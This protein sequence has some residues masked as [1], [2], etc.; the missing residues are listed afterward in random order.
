M[1]VNSLDCPTMQSMVT[2]LLEKEKTALLS[3]EPIAGMSDGVTEAILEGVCLDHE[4]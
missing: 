2:D 1:Y 3:D 4:Q